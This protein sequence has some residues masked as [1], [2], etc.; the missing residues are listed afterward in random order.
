MNIAATLK[1]AARRLAA[2]GIDTPAFDA[3]LLLAHA[4]GVEPRD[5]DKAILLGDALPLDEAA[6]DTMMA[7]RVSREPLQYI[8]GHAP[9]RY[10]DVEVGPGVF[11]PRPET[12]TVV[13]AGIDWLSERGIDHPQVVDLCAGSGVIGLSVAVEIPGS[14]VWAV[15][16]SETTHAW[17]ER[18]RR[19]VAADHPDIEDRYHLTLGDAT[20]AD[21]LRDLDGIIDLV[22][23]NPP[24]IPET[25][26]PE[27]P[28]VRDHDPELALY[29]GS[30]DGLRIPERIIDRSAALLRDG[31]A[32]VMEHDISQGEALREY[33]AA[34]GFADARTGD[35]LAGRPRYLFAAYC[36]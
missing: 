29:G 19:R 10:I 33:A 1:E 28:E 31:G 17:T 7:R 20:D 24:Y 27:Q 12:E 35:D 2:A 34:H 21:T 8:V 11:I 9:F 36:A 25:N 6:F 18:N 30:A 4:A 26:V 3:K 22:I 13:Q 14:E 15:E 5:V 32:L 23:S 16:L